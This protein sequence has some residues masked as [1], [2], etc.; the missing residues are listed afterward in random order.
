MSSS[1]EAM[2][3]RWEE[4]LPVVEGDCTLPGAVQLRN[5]LL[6]GRA[7]GVFRLDLRGVRRCDLAFVQVLW[8]ARKARPLELVGGWPPYLQGL[9][10]DAGFQLEQWESVE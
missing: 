9:L 4:D 5:E 3:C 7:E 2:S 10:R 1:S 6:G 8:A